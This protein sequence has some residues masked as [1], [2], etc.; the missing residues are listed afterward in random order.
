MQKTTKK[1]VDPIALIVDVK[2]KVD[3][4]NIDIE[5]DEALSE[6]LL[7]WV[8]MECVLKILNQIH[9]WIEKNTILKSFPSNENER[10]PVEL[11]FGVKDAIYKVIRKVIS[12]WGEDDSAETIWFLEWA[13]ADLNRIHQWI[14]DNED[15]EVIF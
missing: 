4:A 3:T 13:I 11:I 6:M 7:G 2:R 10:K 8:D 1:S 9:H 12:A 14:L 15:E 5:S